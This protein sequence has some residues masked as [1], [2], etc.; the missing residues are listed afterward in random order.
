MVLLRPFRRGRW[1]R[2]IDLPALDRLDR[3]C[4][5]AWRLQAATDALAGTPQHLRVRYGRQAA[6]V[7]LQFHSPIP[8]WGQRRLDAFGQPLGRVPGSLFA[9]KLPETVIDEEVAFLKETMWLH[10]E[11]QSEAM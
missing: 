2:L 6:E 10:V 3:G 11:G 7:V 5:E 8:S 4:D 9:Y 1:I